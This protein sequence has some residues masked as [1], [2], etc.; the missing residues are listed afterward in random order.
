[1]MG[2][3]LEEPSTCTERRRNLCNDLASMQH[4]L[5]EIDLRWTGACKAQFK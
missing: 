1:M 3:V 4:N 2:F 5:R